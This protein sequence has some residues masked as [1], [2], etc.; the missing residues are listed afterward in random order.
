MSIRLLLHRRAAIRSSL[1]HQL[2]SRSFIEVDTPVVASELLPEIYIDPMK[3]THQNKTKYLQTS[4]E[5]QMKRLLAEDSGPIFQ[6]AQCFRSDERGPLHDTEFTMLEWYEPGANLSSTAEV[7][8]SLLHD[9]LHTKGLERLSCRD[10]FIQHANVDPIT[11][12]L[13]TLLQ[14][15]ASHSARLPSSLSTLPEEQQWSLVFEVLLSDVVSP[16]LGIS[17]PTMLEA[18]PASESAFAQLDPLN[19]QISLRF[20]VF[21][22][23]VEL[24]NGWQE[25]ICSATIRQRLQKTNSAR[26]SLGKPVL[27]LPDRLLSVHDNMPQGVGVALGFDRLVMLAIESDS[28]DT[29]RYFNSDNV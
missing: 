12:S 1:R 19:K 25:E 14:A 29:A 3:L 18:W 11:A 21:V 27:P 15:S 23:G 26:R 8:E 9:S 10:A 4:P 22:A 20:E 6:F 2:E 5:P 16:Q 17:Q 13:S 28:I 24:M 7:I